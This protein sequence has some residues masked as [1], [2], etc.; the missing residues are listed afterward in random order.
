MKKNDSGR[1]PTRCAYL[2]AC[3]I[4]DELRCFGFKTDCALYRKSNG[5][6]MSEHEFNRA[7]DELINKTKAR[8]QKLSLT[9]K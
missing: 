8:H 4:A 7:M 2:K 9:A 6:D 1:I 5:E 3:Y